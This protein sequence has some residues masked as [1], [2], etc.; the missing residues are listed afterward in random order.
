ME[1]FCDNIQNG[2]KIKFGEDWLELRPKLCLLRKSWVIYLE[3][4]R[5]I[6]SN[7]TEK[8]KFDIWFWVFFSLLLPMLNFRKGDCSLRYVSTQVWHFFI[9]SS[10]PKILSLKFLEYSWGNPYTKFAILNITF[11]FTRGWSDLY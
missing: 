10:F 9:I 6:Q 3:Q 2:K 8:E 1:K 11:H 4:N 7:W 5:E